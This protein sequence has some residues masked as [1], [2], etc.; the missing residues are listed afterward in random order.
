VC[1]S[2]ARCQMPAT[3]RGPWGGYYLRLEALKRLAPKRYSHHSAATS[4]LLRAARPLASS[5][6]R[7]IG[8]LG[9]LAFPTLRRQSTLPSHRPT[10][11]ARLLLALP[12]L[13]ASAADAA[14]AAGAAGSA[15]PTLPAAFFGRR[16]TFSGRSLCVYL[17]KMLNCVLR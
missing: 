12:A 16:H 8:D 3:E 14:D 11:P 7:L 4:P 6:P 9:T 5:S 10:L 13:P 15:N 1:V 17:Y 2:D